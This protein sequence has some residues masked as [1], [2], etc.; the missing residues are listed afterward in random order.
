MAKATGKTYHCDGYYFDKVCPSRGLQDPADIHYDSEGW[1]RQKRCVC[2][3]MGLM[4]MQN[5][6]LC[7]HCIEH[8]HLFRAEPRVLTG[9]VVEVTKYHVKEEGTAR[10]VRAFMSES[11][12][13]KYLRKAEDK[14]S[15]YGVNVDSGKLIGI[16]A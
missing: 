3:S 1:M 7:P 13:R 10:T 5:Y 2:E 15:L 14:D 16:K 9:K 12:V 8:K 6:D 11:S 4:P